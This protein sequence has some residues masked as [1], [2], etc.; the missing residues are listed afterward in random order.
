MS[1]YAKLSV[2][3]KL[4]TIKLVME[5]QEIDYSHQDLEDVLKE[6]Q[7]DWVFYTLSGET[8][9]ISVDTGNYDIRDDVATFKLKKR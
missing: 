2:N 8:I 7:G 4:N 5:N 3:K 9:H 6:L 1:Q